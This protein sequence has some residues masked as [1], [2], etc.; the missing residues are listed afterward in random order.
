MK[1]VYLSMCSLFIIGQIFFVVIRSVHPLYGLHA[2]LQFFFSSA[3]VLLYYFL[4]YYSR[5]FSLLSMFPAL[6]II[7][8]RVVLCRCFY[9]L[10]LVLMSFVFQVCFFLRRGCSFFIIFMLIIVVSFSSSFLTTSWLLFLSVFV[11]V[12]LWPLF[13][14][15]SLTFILS[16]SLICCFLFFH[17][18]HFLY[19]FIH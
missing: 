13:T 14:H 2:F 3:F 11:V 16:F 4:L 1:H 8:S 15:P 17:C 6:S 9:F 10:S 18:C 19:T 5:I 7:L 12:C